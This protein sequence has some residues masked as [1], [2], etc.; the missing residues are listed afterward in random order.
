MPT[1]PE[2]QLKADIKKNNLSSVYFMYGEEQFLCEHYAELIAQKGIDKSFADFNLFRL[3]GN[4]NTVDDAVAAIEQLPVMAEK[5]CVML[6]DYNFCSMADADYKKLCNALKYSGEYCITVILFESLSVNPKEKP[7]WKKYITFFEKN[8]CV[9]CFKHY[10]RQEILS[11]I[12]AMAAKRKLTVDADALPLLADYTDNDLRR[13]INELDKLAAYCDESISADDVRTLVSSTIDADAFRFAEAIIYGNGEKAYGLLSDL[14]TL[15]YEPILI[16]GAL[17]GKYVDIYR[18]KVFQSS[19]KRASD[20]ARFYD[21]KRREFV[22]DKASAVCSRISLEQL[23]KSLKALS[24]ADK[25]LKSFSA[26]DRTV[27]EKLIAELLV[28]S[29]ER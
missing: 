20:V 18:V 10:S 15:K 25:S 7:A 26:D 17:I 2:S 24:D 28:I 16:L 9:C 23:K 5:K 27:M 19:G 12:R 14:Y 6:K 21:Y 22:L 3:N 13:L 11:Q 29:A 8:Y 1:I 4:E